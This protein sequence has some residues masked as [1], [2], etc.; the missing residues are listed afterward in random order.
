MKKIILLTMIT[1]GTAMAFGQNRAI[2]Y[3]PT[4]STFLIPKERAQ[5]LEQKA[6]AFESLVPVVDSLTR[7]AESQTATSQ[8]LAEEIFLLEQELVLEAEA[9]SQAL[10]DCRKLQAAKHEPNIFERLGYAV[11]VGIAKFALNTIQYLSK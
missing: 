11:S 5:I 3:S 1:V 10:M 6:R 2:L 8:R 9:T 4:D 7:Y